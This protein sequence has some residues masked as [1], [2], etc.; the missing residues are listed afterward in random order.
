MQRRN[1]GAFYNF[2]VHQALRNLRTPRRFWT[3]VERKGEVDSDS[4]FRVFRWIPWLISDSSGAAIG[5]CWTESAVRI[6]P[7]LGCRG[8]NPNG[9]QF[10]VEWCQ[11]RVLP[12]RP[13]GTAM[14][15][16]KINELESINGK[17][18]RRLRG[19]AFSNQP[20]GVRSADRGWLAPSIGI[21]NFGFR[22]AR[23]YP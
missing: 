15:N 8:N 5:C 12:Y 19:G 11:E 16:D 23:T 3:L 18:P 1:F 6:C 22:L 17:N 4:L 9:R 10:V 21:N 14:I 20:A 2:R 7:D 13:G